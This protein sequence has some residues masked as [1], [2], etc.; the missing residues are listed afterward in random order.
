MEQKLENVSSLVTE[1]AKHKMPSDGE[2]VSKMSS[3]E[4][5]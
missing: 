2:V 4:V 3:D 5:I 1:M